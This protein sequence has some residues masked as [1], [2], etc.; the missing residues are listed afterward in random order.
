MVMVSRS[1]GEMLREWRGRVGMRQFELARI[2]GATQPMVCCYEGGSVT[3]G[4]AMAVAIET[5]SGIPARSWVPEVVRV[6]MA[7]A[8]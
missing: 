5:V 1:A 2:I 7:R 6:T 4:L 3:P 8:A